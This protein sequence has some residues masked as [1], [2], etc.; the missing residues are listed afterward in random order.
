MNYDKELKLTHSKSKVQWWT[1]L[2]FFGIFLT[3]T[4]CSEDDD[5][6]VVEEYP[7]LKIINQNSED[8]DIISVKLVGYD[9]DNLSIDKNNS[10]TFI[11]DNGMSGGY[12]D[13]NVT[14]RMAG[15]QIIIRSIKVDFKEGY[16][17][18]ITS[19]GCIVYEGCDGFYLE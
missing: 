4:T 9:F 2:V 19:K 13:I 16:T 18:S 8:R 14:I 7:L 15:P 5:I 10:Q 17:T 11:L 6:I 12:E 1:I 3:F